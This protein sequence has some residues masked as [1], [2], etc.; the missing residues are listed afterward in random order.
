MSVKAH[1]VTRIDI[2]RHG[3]PQGGDVFRGRVDHE[4]TRHGRWQFEQRVQRFAGPWSCIISSPLQRCLWSAQQLSERLHIPLWVD[5]RWQEI[6]Y[7]D[8]EDALI[9]DVMAGQLAIVQQ[10]WQDPFNFCAPNG[11]PVSD[12]QQRVTQA[13]RGLLHDH[14]GEHVVVVSHGGVMR[15][16]AQFLLLLDPKAMNRLAIPYAGFMRIRVDHT[17]SD[18]GIEEHWYSL[19]ALDGSELS[20]PSTS[21]ASL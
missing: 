17:S 3:E 9:A 18:S 5:A 15:V 1:A 2:I 16:L 4:L 6:H 19:E 12:L 21:D 10:L 14:K 13:W 7:G 8:W 11:E 20:P